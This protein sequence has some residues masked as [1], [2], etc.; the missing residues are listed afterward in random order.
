VRG[1]KSHDPWWSGEEESLGGAEAEGLGLY[2]ISFLLVGIV[3]RE[4]DKSREVA[5]QSA[6]SKSTSL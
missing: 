1:R 6:V 3:T 4:T 5:T 2:C